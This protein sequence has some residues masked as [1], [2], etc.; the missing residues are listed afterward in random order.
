MKFVDQKIVV[1]KVGDIEESP[2]T[3]RR[4]WFRRFLQVFDGDLAGQ[5]AIYAPKK[6]DLEVLQKGEYLAD[7]ESAHGDFANLEYRLTNL[8]PNKPMQQ[9]APKA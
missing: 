4:K 2:E 7:V 8:R 9:Q 3:S 5:H 6:E 1:L